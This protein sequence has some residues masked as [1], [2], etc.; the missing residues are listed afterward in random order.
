MTVQ[1]NPNYDPVYYLSVRMRASGHAIL[2]TLGERH[3]LYNQHGQPNKSEVL[4][5]LLNRGL[6]TLKEGEEL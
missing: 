1:P 2:E 4:R 3:K 5:R 6:S